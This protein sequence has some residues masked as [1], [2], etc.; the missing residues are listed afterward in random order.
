MSHRRRGGGGG[1]GVRRPLRY[2]SRRLDLSHDQID[3]MAALLDTLKTERAQAEVD[4]RRALGAIADAMLGDAFDE[5]AVREATTLR[6][7]SKRRVEAAA[8]DTRAT[9]Y[10]LR[11]PA[12]RHQL[13]YL[14]RAGEL[15]I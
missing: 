12:Q 14:L 2:L 8:G 9:T 7:E 5:E 10:P 6:V 11:G 3:T 13:A 15:T 1:M 4:N